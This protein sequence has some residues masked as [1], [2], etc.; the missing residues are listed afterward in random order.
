MPQTPPA[1]DETTQVRL[2]AEAHRYEI[3]VEGTVAGF[4]EFRDHGSRR[5]FFHTV[6]DDAYA[7]RGLAS[8]L[9]REA[10]EHVRASGMRLVA[11]CPYVAKYLTKQD[12]YR[13]ITDEATPEVR[14]W[15]AAELDA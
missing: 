6:V 12:G 2:A 14:A 3:L 10:L 1:P 5:V 13:D 11:I 7:G 15:L 4:T 9:V 8:I